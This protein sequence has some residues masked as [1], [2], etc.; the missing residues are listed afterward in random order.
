MDGITPVVVVPLAF[1]KLFKILDRYKD[2]NLP[3]SL[4]NSL[5][6][7]IWKCTVAQW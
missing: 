4:I 1:L 3:V 5:P 2:D 7:S 6:L